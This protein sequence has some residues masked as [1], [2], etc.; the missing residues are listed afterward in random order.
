M[1]LGL[2]ISNDSKKKKEV[3]LKFFD[4]IGFAYISKDSKKAVLKLHFKVVFVDFLIIFSVL[5]P[6]FKA[7]LC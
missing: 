4:A 5:K 3:V 2:H 1:H 7:C 6:V